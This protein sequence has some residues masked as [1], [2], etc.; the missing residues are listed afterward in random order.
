[1]GT[2]TITRK[3][4][5]QLLYC[6]VDAFSRYIWIYLCKHKNDEISTFNLFLS[7]VHTQ[8]QAKIEAIQYDFGL[9]F[10]SFTKILQEQG[11][12]HRLTCPHTSH[13]N[14]TF[15]RKHR[16]IVEMGLALLDKASLPL[17]FW[18]HSFTTAISLLN[19]FPTSGIPDYVSSFS[20]VH[21][22]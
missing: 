15:D 17:T 14:E 16:Q 11:I 1:M 20:V 21:N 19:L 8:F 5:L 22:K 18:D 9:E 7:Y 12:I 13:Q 6:I 3:W 2:F 4:W 10:R